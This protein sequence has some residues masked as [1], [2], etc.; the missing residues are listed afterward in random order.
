MHENLQ[1]A[2]PWLVKSVW[3]HASIGLDEDSVIIDADREKILAEM[4][5]RH[6]S[7]GGE[8]LAEVFIDGREIRNLQGLDTPVAADATVDIFPPTAG[9]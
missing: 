5:K 1:I 4:E 7:L 2:G 8:C 6:A 9:G 3:E